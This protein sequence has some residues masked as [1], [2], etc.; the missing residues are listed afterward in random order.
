MQYLDVDQALEDLAHF[1]RYQKTVIPGASNSG[2]IL[3]GA[4]YAGMMVAWFVQ[5]HPTLANGAWS[6]SAPLRAV[7][8]F[9]EYKE[10]VGLAVRTIGGQSCY[11]RLERAF[12][13]IR[14]AM[15]ASQFAML[16]TEFNTCTTLVGAREIDRFNFLDYLS[17]VVSARVQG[18]MGTE[19]TD[20]CREITDGTIAND[21]SAFAAYVRNEVGGCLSFSYEDGVDY[22][23]TTSWESDSAVDSCESM[24]GKLNLVRFGICIFNRATMGLPDVQRVWVLYYTQL[25]QSTFRPV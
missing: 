10:V 12:T 18:N 17:N 7:V 2:V 5:R 6:S 22:L 4:S 15:D 14:N 24:A 21:L 11:D 25:T 20:A 19:I 13:Q 1:I 9:P 3:V 16:D 8:D 23:K